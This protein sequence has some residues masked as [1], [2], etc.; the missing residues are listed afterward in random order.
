MEPTIF[1]R[2]VE[3]RK[4]A[5]T[6]ADIYMIVGTPATRD[7]PAQPAE[8]GIYYNGAG[9]RVSD[10]MAAEAG[11][12]VEQHQKERRKAEALA[13]AGAAI[14]AQ[15]AGIEAKSEVIRERRGFKMI[16]IGMQRYTIHDPDGNNL[17][18]RF[19]SPVIADKVFDQIVPPEDGET[20]VDNSAP[21]GVQ[22]TTSGPM[23][24]MSD[25][26]PRPRAV[27]PGVRSREYTLGDAPSA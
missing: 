21:E 5:A 8:P 19:V 11:F 1:N 12:P 24:R 27:E 16:D 13:A 7:M 9:Q 23:H 6:G 25:T 4:H 26:P 14:D 20:A 10:S 18:P 22:N 2:G 3:I 17:T 15:Y